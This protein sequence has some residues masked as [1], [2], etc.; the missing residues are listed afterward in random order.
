MGRLA[1]WL[2]TGT[3]RAD[4]VASLEDGGVTAIVIAVMVASGLITAAIIARRRS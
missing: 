4:V 3:A 2:A 1:I